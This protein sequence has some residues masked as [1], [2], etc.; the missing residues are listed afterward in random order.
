MLG[1]RAPPPSASLSDAARA[2]HRGLCRR[3]RRN[4]VPE[5][6]AYATA[7][8]GKSNIGSGGLGTL[9]HLLCELF[10]MVAGGSPYQRT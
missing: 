10:K 2:H 8:S 5:F 4:M 1:T 7:N 6:I 9:Q 3:W